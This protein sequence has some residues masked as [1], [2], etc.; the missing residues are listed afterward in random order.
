MNYVD[1]PMILWILINICFYFLFV[2][3][4]FPVNLLLIFFLYLKIVTKSLENSHDVDYVQMLI[5]NVEQY[6]VFV[7]DL[8][9]G[10]QL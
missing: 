9:F 4:L 5:E 7:A 2:C 10:L 3:F 6:L 1:C 8:G